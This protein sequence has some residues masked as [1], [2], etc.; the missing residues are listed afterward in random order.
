MQ[1]VHPR[2]QGAELFALVELASEIEALKAQL[3]AVVGA[4]RPTSPTR[5]GSRSPDPTSM[6]LKAPWSRAQLWLEGLIA[7]RS[8]LK[9]TVV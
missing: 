4:P 2:R 8:R 9:L 6:R 1:L 3:A 7:D 5:P